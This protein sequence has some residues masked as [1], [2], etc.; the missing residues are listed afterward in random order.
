VD[1]LESA[2]AVVID[3]LKEE[4]EKTDAY[5]LFKRLRKWLS[6]GEMKNRLDE[7]KKLI[8]SGSKYD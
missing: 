1:A 5:G 2:L 3:V 6:L 4:M 7:A 8:S